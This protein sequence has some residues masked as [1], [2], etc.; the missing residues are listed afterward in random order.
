[1][2]HMAIL[3]DIDQN[4]RPQPDKSSRSNEEKVH[5][6]ST[7]EPKPPVDDQEPKPAGDGEKPKSMT[8]EELFTMFNESI[9]SRLDKQREGK[10]RQFGK[11]KEEMQKVG[12]SGSVKPS[13][14]S[15]LHT[16]S[17]EVSK[18]VA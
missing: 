9:N 14:D 11:W 17:L 12:Q 10:S 18:N 6:P 1:M 5:G 4:L 8:N 13:V 16:F 15:R 3:H 7:E 2:Q